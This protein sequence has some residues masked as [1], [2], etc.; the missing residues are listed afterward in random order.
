MTLFKEYI[1]PRLVQW[2]LVIFIGVSVTFMIPRLSPV[3]PV[4]QAIGRLTTFQ[5]LSPEA[6]VALRE[7]LED[8]YGL[9]GTIWDQYVAF[10]SRVIRGDLGPS[11]SSF[12][13]EVNTM[14]A[15]AIGWTIGLLGVA[16]LIAWFSGLILGTL[17]GYFPNQWWAR[18]LENSLITIYPVPYF[19][20]AFILLMLLTFYFPLFP[21][22]GGAKGT[23]GFTWTY[24]SSLFRHSFLPAL[25][26]VVG[27]TAFR[28]I[29]SKALTSSEVLATMFSMLKW[30]RCPNERFCFPI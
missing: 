13:M 6:T 29:M 8:L 17:A 10:W 16:T 20:I 4:E 28:F 1:L 21:L 11:F 24:I 22:V 9:D 18:V 30:P 5:N 3:N 15:N 14:I 12:P 23:P 27:A 7:S 19:I 25:S 2:V 26:I